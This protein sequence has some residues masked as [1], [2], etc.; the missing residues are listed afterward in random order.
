MYNLPKKAKNY[1][2]P[3]KGIAKFLLLLKELFIRLTL[4]EGT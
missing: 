2:M 1:F 3:Q 4:I